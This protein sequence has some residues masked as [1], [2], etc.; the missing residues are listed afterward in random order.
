MRFPAQAMPLVPISPRTH[1]LTLAHVKLHAPS[2]AG[3]TASGAAAVLRADAFRSR[4]PCLPPPRHCPRAS[5][6]APGGVPRLRPRRWPGSSPARPKPMTGRC[7][8]SPA[9]PTA[10]TSWNPTCRPCW[11]RDAGPAGVPV[12]RLGN[13]GLRPLQPASGHRFPAPGG[14]ARAA[15]AEAR[16]RGGAGADADAAPAAAALRDRRQLRPAAS[17]RTSTSTRRKRRLEAASYR[18]VPQVLDPGDF[19]DPRRP[20]GRLSDGRR[21]AAAHRAARRQRS[22]RSAPSIRKPSAR[23]KRSTRCR[24]C[25]AAKCRWTTWPCSARW[26]RCANASTW[27]RGAAR[28]T[29]T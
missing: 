12:P 25:P 7:W 18:N 9:T 21:C 11:A 24:C 22:T 3:A 4:N 28:F 23:W 26:M 15:R 8:R 19:A 14:P 20:A 1:G 5:I 13:P 17:A 10:R 29:R 27:T 16:H 2:R 6:C